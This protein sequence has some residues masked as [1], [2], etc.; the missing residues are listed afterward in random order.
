MMRKGETC[1]IVWRDEIRWKMMTFMVTYSTKNEDAIRI[2]HQHLHVVLYLRRSILVPYKGGY[3][4]VISLNMSTIAT[5]SKSQTIPN[6]KPKLVSL[7]LFQHALLYKD[8]TFPRRPA[9]TK[10]APGTTTPRVAAAMV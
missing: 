1:N 8:F 6:H 7:L 2:A 3:I 9:P 5:Q 4:T 10:Q